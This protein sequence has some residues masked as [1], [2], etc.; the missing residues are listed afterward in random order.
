MN[1]LLVAIEEIRAEIG[2]A[3]MEEIEAKSHLDAV[4]YYLAE[5]ER[6]CAAD[7]LR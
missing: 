5:H 7:L 1:A 3:T 6:K 4:A 2:D